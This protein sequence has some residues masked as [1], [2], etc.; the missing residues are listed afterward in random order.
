MVA[1]RNLFVSEDDSNRDEN[2][3][4]RIDTKVEVGT[5]IIVNQDSRNEHIGGTGDE[6]SAEKLEE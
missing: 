2:T 5:G 1:V 4:G 3:S 6:E